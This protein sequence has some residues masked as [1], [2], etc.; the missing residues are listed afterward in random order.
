MDLHPHFT[1]EET[2]FQGIAVS[3]HSLTARRRGTGKGLSASNARVPA[4]TLDDREITG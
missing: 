3:R 2:E 4:I 1:D